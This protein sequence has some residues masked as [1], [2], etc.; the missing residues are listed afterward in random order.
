M[1]K[2]Q[3][4]FLTPERTERSTVINHF[5]TAFGPKERCLAGGSRVFSIAEPLGAWLKATLLATRKGQSKKH[6]Q[7]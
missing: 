7:S 2:I 1:L 5:E 6:E 4:S 3:Q